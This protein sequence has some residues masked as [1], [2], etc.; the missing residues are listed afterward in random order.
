MELEC[1]QNMA[2]NHLGIHSATASLHFR[3]GLWKFQLNFAFYRSAL[4]RS[5][6]HYNIEQRGEQGGGQRKGEREK[7]FLQDKSSHTGSSICKTTYYMANTGFRGPDSLVKERWGWTFYRRDPMN[8]KSNH[9]T[10]GISQNGRWGNPVVEN[11]AWG[12]D[13]QG[14][15]YECGSR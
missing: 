13:L 10:S 1:S 14:K 3:P 11:Q 7:K 5:I 6:L 8:E 15:I 12:L 2:G 4:H 9:F